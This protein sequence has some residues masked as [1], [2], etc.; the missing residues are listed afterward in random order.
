VYLHPLQG[1]VL[2]G[3]YNP[4]DYPEHNIL[5]KKNH[6]TSGI[7]QN[8][9]ISDVVM[10]DVISPIMIC[11]SKSFLNPESKP[12][13]MRNINIHPVTAEVQSINP[14]IVACL[15]EGAIEDVRISNMRIMPA[16]DVSST[17]DFLKEAR[18]YDQGYPETRMFGL[19]LAASSFFARHVKGLY[20]TATSITTLAENVRPLFVLKDVDDAILKNIRYY[21]KAIK[22][23][24]AILKKKW[25]I[26]VITK[27]RL[28]L[29]SKNLICVG[30]R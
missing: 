22:P 16:G 29:A 11:V 12:S 4:A 8:V 14:S 17:A 15:P 13:I 19:K 7:V 20:L 27:Q 24:K 26:A 18:E 6:S 10:T 21:G 30:H 9:K 3:T 28:L 2:Q 1:F 23:N 25:V 5:S